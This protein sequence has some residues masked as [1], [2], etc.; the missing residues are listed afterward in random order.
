MSYFRVTVKFGFYFLF[1]CSLLLFGF[2]S[3][4]AFH[5]WAQDTNTNG[6]LEKILL[7][8]SMVICASGIGLVILSFYFFVVRK[9][10]NSKL[11]GVGYIFLFL[12]IHFFTFGMMHSNLYWFSS[13]FT[14]E[15]L[16]VFYTIYWYRNEYPEI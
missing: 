9:T 8:Y 13:A 15:L 3:F 14:I 7:F 10:I 1:I 5:T 6:L 12:V 2:I 16:L 4:V 11:H